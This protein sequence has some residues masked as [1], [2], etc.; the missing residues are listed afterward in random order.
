MADCAG[1]YGVVKLCLPVFHIGYFKTVITILQD[2]CKGCC[3]VLLEEKQRRAFLKRLRA[4]KLESPQRR[5][6]CKAINLECKKVVHCSYCGC[7]NGMSYKN[8]F[9]SGI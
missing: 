5:A 2:I 4:P 8:I 6:I 9:D 7:I 1:H 3:K